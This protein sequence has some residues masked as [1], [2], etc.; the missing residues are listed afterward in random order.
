MHGI[1]SRQHYYYMQYYM[2]MNIFCLTCSPLFPSLGMRL[3]RRCSRHALPRRKRQPNCEPRT[4]PG[5]Q[6]DDGPRSLSQAHLWLVCIFSLLSRALP[7]FI[8]LHYSRSPPPYLSL[9]YLLNGRV[10]CIAG[11]YECASCV[12]SQHYF[13]N[14]HC[15]LTDV[16]PSK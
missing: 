16:S 12:D 4:V 15:W 6:A 10:P 3:T 14:D 2:C 1:H 11:I 13:F 8:S 9:D 5:L 7:S